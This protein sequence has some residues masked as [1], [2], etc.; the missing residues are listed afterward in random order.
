MLLVSDATKLPVIYHRSAD[1]SQ[2]YLTGST[3]STESIFNMQDHKTHARHRKI[4][5][6]PYSFTNIKKMEPL[7]DMEIHNWITRLGSLFARRTHNH[8]YDS[9]LP[10]EEGKAFDF[11][12]WA[13][14]M[15]YDVVS[16]VGFGEA[17]GFVEQGRDV[18]GLIKGMH[19]GL[20]PFGI[21]A[22]LY[23]FTNWIKRTWVG[24]R[25][26][27]VKPE[28]ENGFGALMRFRDTLIARRFKSIEEGKNV[29]FDLLQT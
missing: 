9:E 7:I 24:E 10:E 18:A 27:V 6:A 5:A 23:P 29:R 20:L 12:P 16:Q 25:Y 4:A 21:M 28:H 2:H 17:F 11:C 26:L 14:Y 19:D 1:K 8:G 13:V 3:G 22:R 15:A